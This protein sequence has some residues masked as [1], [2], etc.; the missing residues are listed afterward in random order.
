MRRV[1]VD[2]SLDLLV[3][4][5]RRGPST[6]ISSRARRPCGARRRRRPATDATERCVGA[7]ALERERARVSSTVI[8]GNSAASWNERIR[9]RLAAV[10]GAE[11]GDVLA[12]EEH[13]PAS[14][15][16]KPPSSS[17]V[18]VLPAPLGPMSPSDL[19]GAHLERHVVDRARRRR[20]ASRSPRRL[21]QHAA[22]AGRVAPDRG[23]GRGRA[24][25]VDV[26]SAAASPRGVGRRRPVD[27][28][29]AARSTR[30][31]RGRAAGSSAWAT[32]RAGRGSA[33]A[34]RAAVA[35]RPAASRGRN[36]GTPMM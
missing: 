25:A 32:R 14:G 1:P 30:D 20:S 9:P 34:S 24:R 35:A 21:E 23:G 16:V 6:P 31:E 5:A 7:T 36:C 33:R 3:A 2:S 8:V 29:D 13:R 10:L 11:L 18:V 19:A 27:A 17:N 22:G 26:S 12:V 15:R 4:V 28:R